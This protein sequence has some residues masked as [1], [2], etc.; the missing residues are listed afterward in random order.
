MFTNGLILHDR[1]RVQ[2]LNKLTVTVKNRCKY[3]CKKRCKKKC[4]KRRNVNID[5]P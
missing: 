2:L 3:R 1:V 5:Y 4:K